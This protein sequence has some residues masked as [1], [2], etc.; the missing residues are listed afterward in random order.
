MARSH[1]FSLFALILSNKRLNALAQAAIVEAVRLDAIE[2]PQRQINLQKLQD[3]NDR[4]EL[5]RAR[6]ENR[7]NFR[8]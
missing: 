3:A 8:P 6:S 1:P 5:D 2:A 4:I 7:P